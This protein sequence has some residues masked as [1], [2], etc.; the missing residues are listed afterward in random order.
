VSFMCVCVCPLYY[1]VLRVCIFKKEVWVLG[2]CVVLALLVRSRV[3]HSAQCR[4][5][6]VGTSG[7]QRLRSERVYCR[8]C[9]GGGRPLRH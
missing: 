4:K 7:P 8:S 5:K 9:C 2:V 3:W 6:D 1:D